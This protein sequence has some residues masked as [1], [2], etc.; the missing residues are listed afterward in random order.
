MADCNGGRILVAAPRN[1]WAAIKGAGHLVHHEPDGRACLRTMY[2]MKP[3]LVLIDV[4]LT[5]LSGWSALGRIREISDVAVIMMTPTGGERDVVRSLRMGADDCVSRGVPPVELLARAERLLRR[6]P[7]P[8]WADDAFEDDRLRVDPARRS[9]VADGQPVRLTPIEFRLLATLTRNAGI[10]LSRRRLLELVWD[11][12]TGIGEERVKFA[13]LRLRR[14]LGW[15]G[16][17]DSPVECV[18]G[19]GYRYARQGPLM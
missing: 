1:D 10:V 16:S 5:D 9:I 6:V 13:V 12:P 17:A 14:R 7:A 4:E 8:R 19:F 15:A 3:D 2:A 11:D 18:R